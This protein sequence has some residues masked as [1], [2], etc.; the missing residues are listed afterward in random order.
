MLWCKTA[1]DDPDRYERRPKRTAAGRTNRYEDFVAEVPKRKRGKKS[2]AEVVESA[3]PVHAGDVMEGAAA[4]A[5]DSAA[6]MCSPASTVTPNNAENSG[7][8]IQLELVPAV[9]VMEGAAASANN[10]SAAPASAECWFRS[11][12]TVDQC[13]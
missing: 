11:H 13:L 2:V 10:D 5:N 12:C 7:C 1:G 9:H 8:D 6:P 4:G 3:V